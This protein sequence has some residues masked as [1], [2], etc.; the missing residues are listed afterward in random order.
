MAK[1]TTTADSELLAFVQRHYDNLKDEAEKDNTD[2]TTQ[3]QAEI[4]KVI[5][6]IEKLFGIIKNDGVTHEEI[7]KQLQEIKKQYSNLKLY[8]MYYTRYKEADENLKTIMAGLKEEEE[9][10]EEEE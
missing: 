6:S 8:D 4:K 9:E 2:T 5:T 10:E 3:N 1:T 7:V